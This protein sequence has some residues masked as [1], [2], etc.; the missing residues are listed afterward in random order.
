MVK[1]ETEQEWQRV[2]WRYDQARRVGVDADAATRF[3]QGDGDVELLRRLILKQGCD[4]ETA[5]QI[6]A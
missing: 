5:V 6:V 2:E 3:A 1:D 4:P